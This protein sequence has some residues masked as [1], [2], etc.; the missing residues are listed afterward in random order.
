MKAEAKNKFSMYEVDDCFSDGWEKLYHQYA[1]RDRMEF[2]N[3]T[4]KDRTI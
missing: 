1:V 3:L 4:F 2:P